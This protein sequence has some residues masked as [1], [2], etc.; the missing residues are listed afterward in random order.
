MKSTKPFRVYYQSYDHS[1]SFVVQAVDSRTA[2]ADADQ[3][4]KDPRD[5]FIRLIKL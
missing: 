4:R 3:Q 2:R 1:Y 5:T